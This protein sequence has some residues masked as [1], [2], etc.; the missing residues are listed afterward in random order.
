MDNSV[1]LRLGLWLLQAQSYCEQAAN[2][3][4]ELS[5]TNLI[6]LQILEG[7]RVVLCGVEVDQ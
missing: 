6:Y 7:C 4:G 1:H 5:P 2:S 3:S